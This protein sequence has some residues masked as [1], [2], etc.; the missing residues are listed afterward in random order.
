MRYTLDY[1]V[2]GY[3][4]GFYYNV[5]QRLL[6]SQVQLVVQ[7]VLRDEVV[8]DQALVIKQGFTE[9][10][11]SDDESILDDFYQEAARTVAQEVSPLFD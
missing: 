2:N 5:E 3:W 10:L 1:I 4:V 6:W 8:L 7:D 9:E 11:K